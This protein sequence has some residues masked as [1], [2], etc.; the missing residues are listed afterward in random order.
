MKTDHKYTN[1]LVACECSGRIRSN[2]RGLG[3]NAYS[4]DIKPAEDGSEFHIQGDALRALH[5][6][7]WHGLIAH[8]VCTRLSN[9]GR[10]W[11]HNSPSGKTHVEM[12]KNFFAGADF[13]CAFRDA[14]H[15]PCRAIEN[16]IMHDHAR[17]YISPRNVQFVQPWHFGDEAFKATGFERVNLPK[18]EHWHTRE[19]MN[20]PSKKTEPERH[21]QW[22]KVHL[23]SPGK[24]R[25]T[26]RSRTFPGIANAIAVQWGAAI[27]QER[28]NPQI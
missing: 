23:A 14:S 6:M 7:E 20:P 24:N 26:L 15:I 8:P 4:C 22:S 10:R 11:L 16:L 13:Y 18:L 3:F 9:S 2:L 27:H 25:A 12:W 28:V 21:A 1:I 19:Q 5:A 17:E